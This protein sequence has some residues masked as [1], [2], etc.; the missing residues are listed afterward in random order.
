MAAA[1]DAE[2][3]TIVDA[4]T[5]RLF[6]AEGARLRIVGEPLYDELYVIAVHPDARSLQAAIDAALVEMR[7]SGELDVMIDRW[8]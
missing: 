2:S 8:L 3:A 4:V 1:S 6:I 5:A 7:E